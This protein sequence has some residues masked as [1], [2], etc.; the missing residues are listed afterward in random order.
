MHELSIMEQ[1]LAIALE[2][3]KRQNAQQIHQLTMKIGAM[4]G[5]VPEALEFAFD[6]VTTKTIAENAKLKI[7]TVPVTCYCL[8]C[9]RSFQ[10]ADLFYTCPQCGNLSHHLLSGREIELTSLEV[11]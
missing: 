2:N 7:E 3:A 4:S 9:D 5:I 1:T 6:V 8:N 11:S 10:P